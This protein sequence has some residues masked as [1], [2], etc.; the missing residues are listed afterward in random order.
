MVG[1]KHG[2]LEYWMGFPKGTKLH[3]SGHSRTTIH[4]VQPQP[5][6]R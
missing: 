6:I 5:R 2:I 3:E 4:I 1:V